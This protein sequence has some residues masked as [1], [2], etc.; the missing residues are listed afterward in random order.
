MSLLT[1]LITERNFRKIM[2]RL[3]GSLGQIPKSCV[4]LLPRQCT[5]PSYFTIFSTSSCM[6]LS[7]TSPCPLFP[8]T[9]KTSTPEE[10]FYLVSLESLLTIEVSRSV[11]L[12]IKMTF[13]MQT[14]VPKSM[15]TEP[16]ALHCR[17]GQESC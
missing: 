17:K 13:E 2:I 14:I 10:E 3:M 8:T 6:L 1:L 16:K 9:R 15:I 5:F 7:F 12:S 4:S 11:S